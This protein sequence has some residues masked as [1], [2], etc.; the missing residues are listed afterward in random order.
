MY[1]FGIDLGGTKTQILKI[2]SHGK[3][4]DQLKIHTDVE[5]GADFIIESIVKALKPLMEKEPPL[6]VGVGV[7]GQIEEK[8]GK[9]LF[10]PNLKWKDVP[11]GEILGNKLK[12]KV[13]VI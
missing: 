3:V 4:L 6:G 11:L 8:S 7:A 10:A 12:T 2:D 13:H 1:A 5:K 9:V